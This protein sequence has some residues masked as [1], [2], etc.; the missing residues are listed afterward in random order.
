MNYWKLIRLFTYF[1][2]FFLT[3]QINDT[4][5][6]SNLTNTTTTTTTTTTTSTSTTTLLTTVYINDSNDSN[7]TNTTTPAPAKKT[8]IS[9]ETVIEIGKN[10]LRINFIQF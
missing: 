9:M 10:K 1:C 2:I 7:V 4:E 6:S 8:K 3:L 5:Q